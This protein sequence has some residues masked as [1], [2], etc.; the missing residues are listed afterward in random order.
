[1]SRVFVC[2]CGAVS[3]AGWGVAA[4]G[5]ALTRGKPVET[6][7]IPIPGSTRRLRV[8][9]VPPTQ[10]GPPAHSRLRRTSPISRYA[11]AAA[12]EALGLRA[13]SVSQASPAE[14]SWGRGLGVIFCSMVGCVNYSR[15]F[16]DETLKEPATASPLVFPETVL[17]APSSH[18][19]AV[20]GTSSINYTLGG[21]P[22]TFLQA[23]ALAGHWLSSGRVDG[24]LVVGA[25]EL[26]WLTVDAVPLF[27]PEVIVSEG[28]GA[29]YLKR[30]PP[31][32]V[33]IELEAVTHAHLFGTGQSRARAAHRARAQMENI[34]AAK[35]TLCDGAQGAPRLDEDER[36]AWQ[37]WRGKR[38]SPKTVLGEGYMAA[39]AWQCVIAR[40][41]I[42]LRGCDSAIVSVVGCNQQA[43]AARFG[44]PVDAKGARP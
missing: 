23:V 3:P 1:M 30:E 37:N 40:Q 15:R 12:F 11:M 32:G 38:I 43:I 13:T 26:D 41:Q 9:S 44:R 8:R 33:A 7:E 31:S 39:A 10:S 21:D 29:L 42:A 22:G 2:G 4:L 20:L 27:D 16:Y 34:D 28:A 5:D 35:T 17:N 6:N 14:P 18:L 25:E 36:G 24:C 19:A